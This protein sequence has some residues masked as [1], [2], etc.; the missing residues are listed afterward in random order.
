MTD[1]NGRL[2]IRIFPFL[3]LLLFMIPLSGCISAQKD[4][5]AFPVSA[6]AIA[7]GDIENGRKLF[8]GY[9]HFEHEG[10][11]CMGCHSVGDNGL[12]GGGSMGPN[13]TGVSE[14]L[15]QEEIAFLLA[16]SGS[17]ISPV[18]QPIYTTHPLTEAEQADLIAF[19]KASA[20][21]PEID[22]EWMVFVLS[23]GGFVAAVA[24]FGFIYRNRLRGVR[25][26]LVRD[27]VKDQK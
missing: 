5:T 8:M 2:N 26:A 9:A 14:R 12:L 10:P 1:R 7:A 23:L 25:K 24:F 18:M 16:N 11:P 21:E 4:V 6:N 22:K 19:M 20:G 13:L 17:E 27:A 3:K 15:T